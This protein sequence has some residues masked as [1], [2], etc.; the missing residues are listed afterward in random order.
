[1]RVLARLLTEG[2]AGGP[3]GQQ[4]LNDPG[5]PFPVIRRVT[6]TEART[7]D[8]DRS[9]ARDG[10]HRYSLRHG[11]GQPQ[12]L[13]CGQRGKHEYVRGAVAVLQLPAALEVTEEAYRTVEPQARRLGAQS[14]RRRA[15]A[16]N[17]QP[18]I[19]P[20]AAQFEHHLEQEPDVL[21]VR[22]AADEQQ[23]RLSWVETVT[24]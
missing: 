14:V 15:L 18:R 8:V 19:A 4:P 23:Q 22:G 12:P 9:H 16:G 1:M 20:K 3:V 21:F 7:Q 2:R 6:A 10:D 5:E 24:A 17:Q 11:P 13:C